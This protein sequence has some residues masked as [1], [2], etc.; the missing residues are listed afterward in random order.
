MGL[1]PKKDFSTLQA[2][3]VFFQKDDRIAAGFNGYTMILTKKQLK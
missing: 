3:E 1:F 2:I